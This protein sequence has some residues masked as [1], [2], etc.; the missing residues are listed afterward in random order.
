M[1]SVSCERM[2]SKMKLVLGDHR[3]RMHSTKAGMVAFIAANKVFYP[4]QDQ[5]AAKKRLATNM[6][7]AGG[8]V[9]ITTQTS[10]STLPTHS[11]TATPIPNER[12]ISSNTSTPAQSSA[13][14]CNRGLILT[15]H[16]SAVASSRGVV[17]LSPST[18]ET[19][20]LTPASTTDCTTMSKIQGRGRG[21]PKGS[22]NK[23]K[24]KK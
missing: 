6:I 14:S 2:F 19:L 21:R 17:T 23:A 10:S 9:V 7:K 4:H 16:R 18:A 13:Q 12:T 1:N 3:L 8:K 11:P 20:P 15:K 22:K 5:P 24:E